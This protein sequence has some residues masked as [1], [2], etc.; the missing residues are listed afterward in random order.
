MDSPQEARTRLLVVVAGVPE[1]EVNRDVYAE[2]GSGWLFRPDL[3]WLGPKVALE[4]DGLDHVRSERRRRD[5]TGRETAD[6]HGWRVLVA[7]S[8]DLRTYRRQLVARVEDALHERGL[9]P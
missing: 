5:M 7:A 4:Y 8:A 1:P 2:D 6:R 9:R 3:R